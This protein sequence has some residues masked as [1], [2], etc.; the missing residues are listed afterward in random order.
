MKICERCRNGK[1]F[2]VL[3]PAGNGGGWMQLLRDVRGAIPDNEACSSEKS[4][5]SFVE[6]VP[7]VSYS[8]KGR[9]SSEKV[10]GEVIVKVEEEVVTE[11]LCYLNQCL[12]F[13][14]VNAEEVQWDEFRSWA[15]QSW[16]LQ[17]MPVFKQVGDGLWLLKCDSRMEVERIMAL[18]RWRFKDVKLQVDKWIKTAGRSRVLLDSNVAWISV[19]GIPLHIRSTNLFKSLGDV[20]GQ[21]LSFEEGDSWSSVRLKIKLVGVIPEEVAVTYGD[22]VYSISVQPD[23]IVSSNCSK[24][25]L[26]RGWR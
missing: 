21:F 10:G 11:R 14:F 24:E 25:G 17:A 23:L 22:E 19:R 1:M 12:V 18:G 2:F 4:Q 15:K 9:C 8:Q 26:L 13:R 16:G 5:A 3:I 7:G 20:C 6:I